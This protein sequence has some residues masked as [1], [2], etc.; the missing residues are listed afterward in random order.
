[1]S[2]AREREARKCP[3]GRF[4]KQLSSTTRAP[5]ERALVNGI[6]GQ[7][8]NG[9]CCALCGSFGGALDLYTPSLDLFSGAVGASR[10]EPR[11]ILLLDVAP[12]L[13][14]QRSDFLGF[15]GFFLY[16][17]DRE[18]PKMTVNAEEKAAVP[19]ASVFLGACAGAEET[20]LR[21]LRVR[22]SLA[23]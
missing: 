7:V 22:S 1:M 3:S 5:H 6:R 20:Q 2:R 15:L 8:G 9:L 18:T 4:D 19:G 13:C 14:T 16:S 11:R 12:R 17:E 23:H 21:E 10:V